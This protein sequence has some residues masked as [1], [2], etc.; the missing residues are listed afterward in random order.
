[1]HKILELKT[2]AKKVLKKRWYMNC[3]T[4]KNVSVL[5]LSKWK[6]SKDK[7]VAQLVG[8]MGGN[9]PN[10]YKIYQNLIILLIC[11]NLLTPTRQ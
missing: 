2:F 6:D 11:R 4:A 7:A 9:T 8:G 10:K 3:E 5:G 1:M